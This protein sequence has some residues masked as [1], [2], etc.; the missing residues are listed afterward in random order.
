MAASQHSLLIDDLG[1]FVAALKSNGMSSP[2]ILKAQKLLGRGGLVKVYPAISTDLQVFEITSVG[3]ESVFI[4][5][6][7]L[8]GYNK[9]LGDIAR[10][11]HERLMRGVRVSGDSIAEELKVPTMLVHHVLITR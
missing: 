11:K 6:Y 3:L 4:G 8:V 1:S 10:I 7:G 9:I 5:E 2:A